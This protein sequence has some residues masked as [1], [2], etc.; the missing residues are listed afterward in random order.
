[1]FASK[2]SKSIFKELYL[3]SIFLNEHYCV[4]R[5]NKLAI[6][7]FPQYSLWCYSFYKTEANNYDFF[8]THLIVSLFMGL[9]HWRWKLSTNNGL[10]IIF[11]GE[12]EPFVH[13]LYI[14]KP[15]GNVVLF[16]LCIKTLILWDMHG[17]LPT[18]LQ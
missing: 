14:I 9:G 2:T 12:E 13:S 16:N 8:F 7:W 6:H 15:N 10:K 1:M 3:F 4:W 11:C 18:Q 17:K 5:H